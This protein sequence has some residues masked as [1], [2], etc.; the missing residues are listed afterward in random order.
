MSSR[1]RYVVLTPFAQTEVVAAVAA[2]HGITAD[3]VAT[4][5]GALLVHDLPVP[6]FD[7]W[8]ISELLGA[9]DG[10]APRDDMPKSA[11]TGGD[12][13]TEGT[14]AGNSGAESASVDGNSGTGSTGTSGHSTGTESAGNSGVENTGT[15]GDSGAN[16]DGADVHEAMAA[17]NTEHAEAANEMVD[18]DDPHAVAAVFSGLSPYGVVLFQAE[19]GDDVGGEDGVSGLVNAQRVN[20]GKVGEEISAGLLLNSLDPKLEDIVLGLQPIEQIDPHVIHPDRAK[21]LVRQMFAAD[22]PADRPTVREQSV[23]EQS[24]RGQ[25]SHIADTA[26]PDDKTGE[27]Q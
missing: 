16:G 26:A 8:D 25:P 12:S 10:G 14:N 17:A 19:L 21:D 7:D 3:V 13:A 4:E 11:G 6:V 1:K 9:D 5:S 18:S 22:K 15:G 24:V 23:E 27:S 20:A 2:L